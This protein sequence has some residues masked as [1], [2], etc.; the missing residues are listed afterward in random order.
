LYGEESWQL[1][2]DWVA[3]GVNSYCA[4]NMVLDTYGKSL[5]NWPQNALIVVDRTAK[6]VI[7]TP[8]YYTF[9]HFSQYIDSGATRLGTTGDTNALAFVNPDGSIITQVYNKNDAAKTMTVSVT[10]S[11]YQ[12]EIPAHAWATFCVRSPAPTK[13]IAINKC[14]GDK[15]GLRITGMGNGYRIALPSRE[16]GRIDLL[17]PTGR[18]LESRVLPQGSREILLQK[19]ASQSGLMIVRVVQGG[20]IKTA[21]LVNDGL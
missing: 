15:N 6:K 7:I 17:T 18:V 9:R 12:F 14:F 13:D 11:L 10:G 4:W 16:P 2:R 19:R 20:A 21:R 8:A 3:A 5:G 1:I